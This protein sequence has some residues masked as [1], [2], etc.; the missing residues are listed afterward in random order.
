MVIMSR[1]ASSVR[2][3]IGR[4][5]LAPGLTSSSPASGHACIDS[6]RALHTSKTLCEHNFAEEYI[7][8]IAF[9]LACSM[10]AKCHQV[11]AIKGA[12][13]GTS[14]MGLVWGETGCAMAA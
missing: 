1:L 14:K 4:S 6:L 7:S 3:Q 8:H 10:S 2:S 13:Q 9:Q 12:A 5:T 11:Q